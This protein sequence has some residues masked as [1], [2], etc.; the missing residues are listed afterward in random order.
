MH[1]TLSIRLWLYTDILLV[2]SVGIR[3]VYMFLYFTNK[4][5]YK[6]M[7]EISTNII[8]TSAQNGAVTRKGSS[9]TFGVHQQSVQWTIPACLHSAYF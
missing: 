4:L 1:I 6:L 3:N 7:I 9:S 2:F 8:Y 5:Q